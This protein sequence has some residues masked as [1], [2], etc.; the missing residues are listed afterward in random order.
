MEEAVSEPQA[1]TDSRLDSFTRGEAL[2]VDVGAIERDLTMLWRQASQGDGSTAVTR[3]CLWNLIFFVDNE[4]RFE[5]IKRLIDDISPTVPARA[6]VLRTEEKKEGDPELEATIEANCKVAPGGGKL[7]CSEEVTIVGRGA[8]VDHFPGVLRAL[9][10][11]DV[12]VTFFWAGPPPS[13][14]RQARPLLAGV[15]RLLVDSGDISSPDQIIRLAQFG[16]V[17]TTTTDLADLGWLRLAP[18]R[19]HIASLFDAPMGADPIVTARKITIEATAAGVASSALLL[20]WFSSRLRWGRPR[21]LAPKPARRWIAPR[22][23][24]DVTM[25]IKH[26]EGADMGTDGISSITIESAGGAIYSLRRIDAEH[27]EVTIPNQSPRIRPASIHKTEELTIA[28]L[29]TRGHD[30]LF[31]E[32][33]TRAADLEKAAE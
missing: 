19:Y 24:G 16:A 15:N 18:Y 32:A 9:L 31:S 4:A 11:P 27:L 29:G 6:L 2:R 1:K 5:K 14:L 10:V 30:P 8:G 22:M 7:L 25:E 28:A 17:A 20:G 23:G 26:V 13:D 21:R 12:P 3:A 33:L